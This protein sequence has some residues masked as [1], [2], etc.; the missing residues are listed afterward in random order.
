MRDSLAVGDVA[1]GS[2]IGTE[3]P[4]ASCIETTYRTAPQERGS[5][6]FIQIKHPNEGAA[7]I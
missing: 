6:L 4:A 5:H 3:T 7:S 1:L 2:A